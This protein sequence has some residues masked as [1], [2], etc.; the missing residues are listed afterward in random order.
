M[1]I[2]ILIFFKNV[3][4]LT[5]DIRY[6]YIEQGYCDHIYDVSR[7]AN[8]GVG[9]GGDGGGDEKYLQIHYQAIT[10]SYIGTYVYIYAAKTTQLATLRQKYKCHI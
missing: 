9:W 5:I 3:D 8:V 4:I 6:R 10:S 2:S 7:G 1:T